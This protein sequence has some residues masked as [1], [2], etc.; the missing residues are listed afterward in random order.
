MGAC[1]LFRKQELM[2]VGG[3]DE[4]IFMYTEEVELYLR[5]KKTYSKQIYFTSQ[6][7][8]EHLGSVSTK[9][10]KAYR[11]AYELKGIEY[12]YKKHYPHLLWLIKG[13]ISVG[14][15]LR[16]SIFSMMPSRRDTL[17]EYKK[18]FESTAK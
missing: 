6:A 5:L 15:L 14:V 7:Q 16:L 9:K 17:V 4:Q 12:I 10:A 11:L 13:I 3:F 8:V 2:Q 1:A 18:Y